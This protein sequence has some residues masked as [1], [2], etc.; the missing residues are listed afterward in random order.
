[1]SAQNLK[2]SHGSL[3]LFLEYQT[4]DTFGWVLN[5]FSITMFF[6]LPEYHATIGHLLDFVMKGL[7]VGV[8]CVHHLSFEDLSLGFAVF[9]DLLAFC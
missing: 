6:S 3:R 8:Q 7:I 2:Q 4:I 1:M 9:D 5:S